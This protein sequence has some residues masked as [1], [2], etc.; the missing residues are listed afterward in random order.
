MDYP[1]EQAPEEK[2]ARTEQTEYQQNR[3]ERDAMREQFDTRQG[4]A[5]S[6]KEEGRERERE[7]D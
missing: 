1:R 2:R 3:A 4:P 7:R 5:Q 6:N